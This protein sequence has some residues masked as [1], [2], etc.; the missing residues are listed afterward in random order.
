MMLI[1]ASTMVLTTMNKRILVTGS[2][3]QLGQSILKLSEEFKGFEFVFISYD[4]LDLSQSES[5]SNYFKSN[6]FNIIIN[7]AAYTAVDKAE[8]EPDLADK[9]NHI[10]A[11]EIAKAAKEQD[12]A[13][14]HVSTDYVFS[15]HAFIPYVESDE[16]EPENVYGK[17]KLDGE[18]AVKEVNPKGL[19]L[20]TSWVYSEYGNNFVKTMLRLGEE[21]DELG[22]I[23][24]QIGAPTY[25]G[26]LAE[27][28]L[29]IIR[30]EAFN[31]LSPADDVYHYSN[32]G[33][34]SWYDFAEAI[35]EI[36]E[37]KCNVNPIE[38]KEYP[39]PAVRPAYSLM[40][41]KKIRMKFGLTI[42]Y[43]K[44]SLRLCL[45]RMK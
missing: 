40:N 20:R 30:H 42:P 45:R 4:E 44:D 17:T 16:T 38:T 39:A 29:E 18:L 7:C 26:D 2:K 43:W 19:I 23:F 1:C 25:A 27:T 33:V 21:R 10:A 13:L 15:G 24:D 12:A 9:V 6:K 11:R 37:H 5:I 36:V 35:F 3:G 41:K 28:I 14:V 8:S 22:V 31:D 32:E 34:A